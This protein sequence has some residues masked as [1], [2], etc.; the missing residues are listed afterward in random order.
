MAQIDR[1]TQKLTRT[2]PTESLA[3]STH[4]YVTHE[5]IVRQASVKRVLIHEINAKE[6]LVFETH[7]TFT[8]TD[9]RNTHGKQYLHRTTTFTLSA[10]PASPCLDCL[11]FGI[12]PRRLLGLVPK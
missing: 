8:P 6:G 1:V 12:A 11:G 9:T 3:T 7:T 10:P 5:R 4:S 2:P